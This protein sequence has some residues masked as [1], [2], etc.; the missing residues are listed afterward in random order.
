MEVAEQERPCGCKAGCSLAPML[1]SQSL[2]P[3]A[4]V[5]SL[6]AGRK[7]ELFFADVTPQGTLQ[8]ASSGGA[9][10]TLA[11]PCVWLRII[12]RRTGAKNLEANPLRKISYK[13]VPLETVAAAAGAKRRSVRGA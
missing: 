13:G 1:A 11:A 3:G 8:V 5:L 4:N 9:Q 2:A 12:S 10:L 6:C 7:Q